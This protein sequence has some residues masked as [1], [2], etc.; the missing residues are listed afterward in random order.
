MDNERRRRRAQLAAA[1]AT[2]AGAV[3]TVSTLNAANYMVYW[4]E[5]EHE[6]PTQYKLPVPFTSFEFNLD[7]LSNEFTMLKFCFSKEEIGHIIPYLRL[8]QIVWNSRYKTSQ[9]L[10]FCILLGCL[11]YPVRFEDMTTVFGRSKFY[12][13]SIF[14]DMVLHIRDRFQDM[15]RWDPHRLTVN[16]L[17]EY[18][19]HI[20]NLGGGDRVWGY[21]DG[22]LQRT[23]RPGEN[24]RSV[25]SGHKHYH[26]FKFQ[27][28]L[29]PDGLLSSVFGPVVGS[30]GDWMLFQQSSIENNIKTL[31]ETAD[32]PEDEWLYIYGDP[33]YTGSAATIG[34]YKKPQ[35]S[36]LT[37]SQSQFNKEMSQNR[38]AVEHGFGLVQHYWAKSAYH[39][40][41][42]IGLSPVGASYFTACLLTNIMT[43]LHGNQVSKRFGCPAPSFE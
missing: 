12:I 42:K 31:F 16:R 32:I 39:L 8:D 10:A 28:V 14:T 1:A 5:Y 4:Q 21:I 2:L 11:A 29:T 22:T 26:G 41:H 35:N 13:S 20:D 38:V 40:S 15:L 3:A 37:A 6:S 17:R 27:A 24:Q 30:C 23:T 19:Q 36:Q 43:C 34:A 25:Y 18:A 9:E 7:E 33:A